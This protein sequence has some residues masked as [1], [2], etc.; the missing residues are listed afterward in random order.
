MQEVQK[1][2]CGKFVEGFSVQLNQRF[3][4]Y[5]RQGFCGKLREGFHVKLRDR[6]Y[7]LLGEVLRKVER[8]LALSRERR[9]EY[10]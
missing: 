10:N 6:F 3:R 8:H 1:W 2:F 5:S 7:K 9:F 4:S